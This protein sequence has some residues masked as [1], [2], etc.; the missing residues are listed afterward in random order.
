MKNFQNNLK[1]KIQEMRRKSNLF[2]EKINNLPFEE[3]MKSTKE[4]NESRIQA[5]TFTD[6]NE[7]MQ[8]TGIVIKK[9]D[10]FREETTAKSEIRLVYLMNDAVESFLVFVN[11]KMTGQYQADY[12]GELE[13]EL[14][15]E[16][17]ENDSTYVLV[18][19][20][21]DSV[22]TLFFEDLKVETHLYRYGDLGHFWVKGYEY[23]RQLEYR[24]AILHTKCE[25]LGADASS[26]EERRLAELVHFPPLNYAC[27]PAVPEKYIVPMD[28]VWE[29]TEQAISIMEE[30]AEEAKD[31][32]LLRWLAFYRKHHGKGM[33]R[34]IAWM[35]HRVRHGTIV[36]LLM[37]KLMHVSECYPVRTYEIKGSKQKLSEAENDV[38]DT[39]EL[40]LSKVE[41][42]V[43]DTGDLKLSETEKTMVPEE[44]PESYHKK[45]LVQA[46]QRKAELEVQGKQVTLVREEPFTTAQDSVEYNIYLMIWQKKWGNRIVEVEHFA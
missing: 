43:Q 17:T 3:T 36:D 45:L 19:H 41:N 21:G 18:V 26:E 7:S 31:R 34:L 29:P 5:D 27:Y 40:K 4:K 35:L 15:R 39:G 46:T 33:S 9:S 6:K 12:E 2:D 8:R 38:A 32:S 16:D 42:N 14:S 10:L 11:A 22:V 28:D 30:L 13:A 44:N 1:K 37:E 25:Y 24:L 23:L 20:Q